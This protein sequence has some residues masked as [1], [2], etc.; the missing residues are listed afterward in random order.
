MLKN[1]H[2]I[3]NSFLLAVIFLS[4]APRYASSATV[5][6]LSDTI[7]NSAPSANANHIIQFTAVNSIPVSGKIII[8]PQSGFFTIPGGLDYTDIDFLVG[9]ADKTLAATAGAG[10]GSAIGVAVAAGTSGSIA[11][12][13]NN[14]DVISAA[15]SIKI[16]I[17]TNASYGGAGDQQIQNPSAVGSYKV[18]IETKNAVS[19]AIDGAD[20]ML[21]VVAPVVAGASAKPCGMGDLNCDGVVNLA[22]FSIASYWYQQTLS[23]A[24]ALIEAQRLSNDGQVTLVDFSIMAYYYTG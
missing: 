7:S 23:P 15:S 19:A 2:K 18:R 3:L 1:L 8:T 16:Y 9:G 4:G 5:L 14:A 20:A 6:F 24:F 11:F 21:A 13:L 10:A 12:S 17:G 22:D